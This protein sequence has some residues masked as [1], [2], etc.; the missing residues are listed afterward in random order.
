MNH[1]TSLNL[2]IVYNYILENEGGFVDIPQDKG[3]PTNMGITQA[4]LAG[5]RKKSVLAEDI[6]QLSTDEALDIY[7]TRY[8]EPM[9][10]DQ[11]ALPLACCLGDTGVLYGIATAVNYAQ[12][13]AKMMGSEFLVIDGQ[14]GPETLTVLKVINPDMFIKEYA[15][16]I[17]ARIDFIISSD[18]SQEIFRAGWTARANK[19]SS[20]AGPE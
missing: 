10:V 8:L 3:G 12:R 19:L 1:P 18:P 4:T 15:A 14:M 11:L 13:V 17:L 9:G 5:W 6:H 7:W 2:N 20:L 16:L